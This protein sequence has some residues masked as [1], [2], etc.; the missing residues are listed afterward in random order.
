VGDQHLFDARGGDLLGGNAEAIE[1]DD[2]AGRLGR[3]IGQDD[4]E[5]T[6]ISVA[7]S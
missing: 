2:W 6:T 5:Y 1:Q 3:T 4:W 7:M